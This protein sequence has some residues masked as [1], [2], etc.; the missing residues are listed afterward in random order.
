[1]LKTIPP[2]KD[3]CLSLDKVSKI[4]LKENDVSLHIVPLKYWSNVPLM[5]KVGYIYWIK[6]KPPDLW[7]P[8]WL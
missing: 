1:M 3:L 7:S 8:N 2:L 6:F 5:R 4:K